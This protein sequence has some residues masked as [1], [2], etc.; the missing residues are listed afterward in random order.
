MR[1]K[2]ISAASCLIACLV[3]LAGRPAIAGDSLYGKITEVRS[4][5]V[6]TLDYG[7]GQYTIRLIGIDV[8]GATAGGAREALAGLV[9][10]KNA[11]VRLAGFENGEMV[12]RLLVDDP[13]AGAKDVGIEMLRTGLARRQSGEGHQFDYKYGEL[14]AAEAEARTARRGLWATSPQ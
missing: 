3:L 9:L 14:S 5:N 6:V 8:P 1:H 2:L 10:G 4:G 7:A 12:G 11:R 13:A